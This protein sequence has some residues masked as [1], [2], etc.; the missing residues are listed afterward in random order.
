[1]ANRLTM[2]KI[3][4]I[5]SLHEQGWRNRQ[6]AREL[7]VDRASVAKHVRAALCDPTPAKAPIGSGET[8][9]RAAG[10]REGPASAEQSGDKG[11][12]DTGPS[13]PSSDVPPSDSKPAK[14][15]IGSGPKSATASRSKSAKASLGLRR[16]LLFP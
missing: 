12:I 16:Q 8:N 13:F 11:A 1:M 14:A 4:A 9:Q 3:Q 10:P 2:A 5:L 15:P 6:I 7:D